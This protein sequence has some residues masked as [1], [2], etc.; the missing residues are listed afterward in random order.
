MSKLRVLFLCVHNSARSQLAE[1]LLRHMAGDHFEVYSAGSEPTQVNPYARRV[2][3]AEGVDTRGLYSKNVADLVDQPFDYVITL[4]AE[5][6]CPYWAGTAVRLHWGMPDPSAVQ[7]DSTEKLEAFRQ[8]SRLL[9]QQ[10]AAFLETIHSPA[11][12]GKV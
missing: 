4:C 9:K 10:L 8:T 6:V 5:E 3:Q 7:G 11:M 2:L 12:R 1:A